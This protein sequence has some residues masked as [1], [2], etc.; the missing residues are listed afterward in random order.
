MQLTSV[1]EMRSAAGFLDIMNYRH[2]Y[3]A[4][5]FADILK[6]IVLARCVAHLKEK[7]TP[8]RV[9]DTHAGIG[10]YDLKSSQ[11]L[12]TSEAKSGI[13]KLESEQWPDDIAAL[14][15]PYREAIDKTR[16]H[17]GESAYPGSPAIVEA[18]LRAED[19]LI[20]NELHPEDYT[21]LR[22]TFSFDGRVKCLSL[23]A[24]V[25][26]NASLPP[27]ERRG[28]V[29][30]DPPYEERNEFSKLVDLIVRAHRKWESGIFAIWYP[31]KSR[32][33]L[34]WFR[35]E[36]KK[37]GIPK[38]LRIE[39]SISEVREGAALSSSGMIVINP[40]WRLHDEMKLILPW[41]D[42]VLAQATGHM[43]QLEWIQGERVN[44]SD[45]Q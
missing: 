38:I 34:N 25:A 15:Q 30:I 26:L 28:L 6:H 14:L 42:R 35:T 43:W 29:L 3:H 4:G 12:R 7:P 20:A 24:S 39:H 19:R 37:T 13:V 16:Q 36:L 23:D 1:I 11:A 21:T 31:V 41:L 32:S 9:I 44:N 33:E 10:V 18:L 40:P 17:H 22:D 5:N 27:K 45:L 2:A 8:F